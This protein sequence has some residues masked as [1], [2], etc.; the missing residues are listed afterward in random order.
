M[1]IF[2]NIYDDD[3][4]EQ[5][6]MDCLKRWLPT[7][8]AEVER[9]RGLTPPFY[10]RPASYGIQQGM[11]KWPEDGLPHVLV[12][13]TGNNDEPT[14]DG[15]GKGRARWYIGVAVVVGNVNKALTRRMAYRYAAAVR[16]LLVQKQSLDGAL[17]GN[18]RGLDWVDGRAN[19]MEPN[20][21]R[22][23]WAS[24]QVFTLEVDDV[25]SHN[26]GPVTPDPPDDPDEPLPDY[27]VV[28]DSDH[29]QLDVENISPDDNLED[30]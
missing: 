25:V 21:E 20:D 2:G 7:Y 14:R 10:K 11:E 3:Q 18:V 27:P 23:V 13:A 19:E 30:S 5:A 6:V 28:P 1:T 26:R 16:A 24:R 17:D 9:Q 29:I 4:I 15:R 22:T 8:L 12:V